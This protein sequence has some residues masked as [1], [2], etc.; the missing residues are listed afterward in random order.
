M[1]HSQCFFT[2]KNPTAI[3]YLRVMLL[4]VSDFFLPFL[5]ETKF[6]EILSKVN[7]KTHGDINKAPM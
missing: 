6:M 5:F 4:Q 7:L 3:C 1:P 2:L